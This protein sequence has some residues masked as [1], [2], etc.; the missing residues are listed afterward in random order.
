MTNTEIGNLAEEILDDY[1]D[2]GAEFSQNAESIEL[3]RDFLA[4]NLHPVECA[5]RV[6]ALTQSPEILL[7]F[8]RKTPAEVKRDG[9]VADRMIHELLRGER[10]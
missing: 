4:A 8:L 10:Q 9:E 5:I 7:R 3:F 1:V 6:M 2:A